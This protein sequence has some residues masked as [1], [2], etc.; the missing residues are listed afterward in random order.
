MSDLTTP[1]QVN[2]ELE[3]LLHQVQIDL[4]YRRSFS[5]EEEKGMVLSIWRKKIFEESNAI[6]DPEKRKLFFLQE[7][8]SRTLDLVDL[9]RNQ[10]HKGLVLAM[11][12]LATCNLGV[13]SYMIQS[14]NYRRIIC[15]LE[16]LHASLEIALQENPEL[17]KKFQESK[18]NKVMDEVKDQGKQNSKIADIFASGCTLSGK[19]CDEDEP[20]K[21]LSKYLLHQMAFSNI[22]QEI[23]DNFI[24]EMLD[25]ISLIINQLKEKPS[26]L[27]SC[28]ACSS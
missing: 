28:S 17:L 9:I 5:E 24:K 4:L 21:N 14:Q 2:K 22:P 13:S 16:N 15:N 3:M 27:T 10:G 11:H 12:V 19:L 6:L 26:A 25:E 20:T 23:K 18:F 8:R 7:Y 1:R